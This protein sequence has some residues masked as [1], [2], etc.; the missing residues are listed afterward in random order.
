MNI[1]KVLIFIVGLISKYF[2]VELLI[3]CVYFTY[4]FCKAGFYSLVR[5]LWVGSKCLGTRGVFLFV[6]GFN[7]F[8]VFRVSVRSPWV[9]SRSF[10][11]RIIFLLGIVCDSFLVCRASARSSIGNALVHFLFAFV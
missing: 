3:S 6:V 1:V 11:T 9:N 4:R 8:V 10:D 2:W 7:S 5:S